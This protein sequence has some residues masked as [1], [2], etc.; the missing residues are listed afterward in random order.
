MILWDSLC[1][2]TN[3]LVTSTSDEW[4]V[5]FLYEREGGSVVMGLETG[6]GG[7]SPCSFLALTKTVT[8]V[9]GSKFLIVYDSVCT[10][11]I[12]SQCDGFL[13]V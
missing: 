11:F 7:E 5:D 3:E 8:V 13:R 6:L 2:T 12:V 9:L 1:L 4:D 10:S